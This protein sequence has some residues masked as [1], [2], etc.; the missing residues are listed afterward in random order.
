SLEALTT[1]AAAA[2]PMFL[3][4]RKGGFTSHIIENRYFFNHQFVKEDSN[5]NI[6]YLSGEQTGSVAFIVGEMQPPVY[7]AAQLK[8][9]L[10]SLEHRFY[11]GSH[12]TEDTS[13][14]NLKYL[15]S[16]QA[17]ED[18]AEFIR[19]INA[20]KGGDQKWIVVGGSYA[21]ALSAWSRL[22][23]PELISGSIASSGPVLAQLDFYGYLQ[24]VDKDFKK[25]GGLCYDQMNINFTDSLN[26]MNG[27]EYEGD[28]GLRLWFYQTCAEFGY[29]QSSNR[30]S[31]VFGQTQSS[32]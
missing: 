1:L 6:I 26:E 11:G 13:V 25:I 10:Y 15:S 12:P 5:V 30:G 32:K 24:T 18:I 22:K 3:G 19:H 28:I 31:N 23:H 2:P 7:Y 29:F 17:I 27:I 21:G 8:A 9:D 4:R 20:Q 16:R 14:E